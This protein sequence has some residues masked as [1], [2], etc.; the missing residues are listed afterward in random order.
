MFRA[1]VVYVSALFL[2]LALS[3]LRLALTKSSGRVAG[4]S[5]VWKEYLSKY[6]KAGHDVPAES[7]YST[8]VNEGYK[9]ATL[10]SA[11]KS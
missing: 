6:R 8:M 7:S 9:Y 1:L 10:C 4:T 11:G 5:T 3:R 2:K